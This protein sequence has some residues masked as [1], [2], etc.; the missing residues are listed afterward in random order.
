MDRFCT[1]HAVSHSILVQRWGAGPRESAAYD[2]A[3]W[4]SSFTRVGLE[5]EPLADEYGTAL[6]QL[7]SDHEL[8]AVRLRLSS[9]STCDLANPWRI[10]VER[11]VEVQL[12]ASDVN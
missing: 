8:A 12:R 11:V 3:T 1:P 4:P 6:S 5:P 9:L 7:P 10:N 2:T